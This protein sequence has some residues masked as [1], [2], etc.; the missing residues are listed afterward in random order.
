MNSC[1][2]APFYHLYY[3]FSELFV[4]LISCCPVININQREHSE[5]KPPGG[6]GG[7]MLNLEQREVGGEHV[8]SIRINWICYK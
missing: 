8:L 5:N 2:V 1:S 4:N 6:G 3:F 7:G